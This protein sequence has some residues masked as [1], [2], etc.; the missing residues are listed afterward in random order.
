MEGELIT[1][2]Q[3]WFGVRE[4]EWWD[5]DDEEFDDR[6]L[7]SKTVN[8]NIKIRKSTFRHDF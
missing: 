1:H 7:K 8:G 6:I 2:I 3:V 4:P 5:E